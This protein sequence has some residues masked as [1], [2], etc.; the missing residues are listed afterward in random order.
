MKKQAAGV[1]LTS[2]AAYL[3]GLSSSRGLSLLV[4]P[5]SPLGEGCYP[6]VRPALCHLSQ[7]LGAPD[8]NGKTGSY[9]GTPRE[10][11]TQRT[12][13]VQLTATETGNANSH[14][15]IQ[16]YFFASWWVFCVLQKKWA[17]LLDIFGSDMQ[18]NLKKRKLNI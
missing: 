4:G 2:L 15:Q 1:C 8:L 10:M 9:L 5:M 13:W 3:P 14:L 17:E 6:W 7:A 16:H 12:C 18:L 11:D